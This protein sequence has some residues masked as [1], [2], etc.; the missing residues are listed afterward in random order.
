MNNP[1]H[2]FWI[3][4]RKALKIAILSVMISI[5]L[6]ILVVIV[7]H[8]KCEKIP[9]RPWWQSALIYRLKLSK[10]CENNSLNQTCFKSR[11]YELQ[12]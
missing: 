8:P 5:S 10:M 1:D 6:F 4:L 9:E 11:D 7:A 2:V 12:H 3:I